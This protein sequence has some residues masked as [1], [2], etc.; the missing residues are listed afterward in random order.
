MMSSRAAYFQTVKSGTFA[1]LRIPKVVMSILPDA[2]LSR[3]VT[4][5]SNDMQMVEENVM[6]SKEFP[7]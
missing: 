6:P 1:E 3:D 4:L 2:L 5:A 7:E